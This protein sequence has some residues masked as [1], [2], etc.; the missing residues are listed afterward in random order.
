MPDFD[1]PATARPS[2]A[3]VVGIIV[4]SIIIMIA[5]VYMVYNY[6]NFRPNPAAQTTSTTAR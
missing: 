5:S 6:S 2:S 4:V 1:D 3:M